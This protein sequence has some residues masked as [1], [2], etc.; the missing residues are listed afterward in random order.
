[1]RALHTLLLSIIVLISACTST[2]IRQNNSPD[3]VDGRSKH[4]STQLYLTGQGMADNLIDAKDRARADLAKQFEVAI[5]ENSLQQQ[6]YTQQQQDEQSTERLQQSITRQLITQTTRTVQ[7]IEIADSWHDKNT[8]MNHALAVLSRNKAKQ[9]FEQ[10]INQLDQQSS[11]KTKQ[12]EAEKNKLK[13]AAVVQQAIN[14]QLER[15]AVQS[16]LQVVDNSGRGKPETISLAELVRARDKLISEIKISP[17]TV[18]P[19]QQQLQPIL[20]GSTASAGFQISTAEQAD[21][22]LLAE[23]KL[24]P[25]LEKNRWIW[26]LGTLKLRLIDQNNNDIGIQ[27]WPIKAASATIE[28]TEQRLLNEINTILKKELRTTLL[29]FSSVD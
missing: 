1:M 16:A 11:Q 17:K 26:L 14:A 10:K 18:G 4:Y 27:R 8:G 9:N 6:K 3:W 20:S 19:Q 21:Y 25:A 12:A 7:G 24:N 23:I 15:Q 13:K 22:T 28:Q 5:N 2:A 29:G